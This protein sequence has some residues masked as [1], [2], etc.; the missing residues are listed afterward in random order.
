MTVQTLPQTG[1]WVI[2]P[3]HSQIELTARHLMVTKV[4]GIFKEFSG[5]L[6]IGESPEAGS[7]EVSIVAA[8][9]DTGA[10]D[11]DN[12]L[13]SPDFLDAGEYPTITFRSTSVEANGSSYRLTGDLTIKDVTRPITLDMEYL[14]IQA[15][16][17]GNEKAAFVATGT[18]DREDWGLEWNVAL[19]AGGWLVSKQFGIDIV[20][21]AAQA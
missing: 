17:W 6:T 12:H 13:R 3:S 19:E 14:G 16:P 1:T 18:F 21:Q 11:R 9:I 2:D 15:D 4:R 5:A 20:I 7:V 8:S 10:E